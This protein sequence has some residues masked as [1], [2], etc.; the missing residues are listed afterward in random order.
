MRSAQPYAAGE[1]CKFCTSP[2]GPM[3][4]HERHVD[5]NDPHPPGPYEWAGRLGWL[6]PHARWLGNTTLA[7]ARGE[8][9]VR[10]R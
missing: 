7:D 1:R 10:D 2:A 5:D 8:P 9:H 6:A 4:T 3:G